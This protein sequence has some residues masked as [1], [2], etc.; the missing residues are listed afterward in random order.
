MTKNQRK[1]SPR[2]LIRRELPNKMVLMRRIKKKKSP[3]EARN[4]QHK[5]RLVLYVRKLLT[6]MLSDALS[7]A[8]VAFTTKNALNNT[9]TV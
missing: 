2:E 3:R 5:L 7:L 4:P 8:R 1:P 6:P 9:S